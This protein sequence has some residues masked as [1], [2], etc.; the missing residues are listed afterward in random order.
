MNLCVQA[1]TRERERARIYSCLSPL[2][3]FPKMRSGDLLWVLEMVQIGPQEK[4]KLIV[5]VLL[6]VT[7]PCGFVG[8]L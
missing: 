7:D 1:R 8:R 3:T 4:M 6:R 5:I 2:Q